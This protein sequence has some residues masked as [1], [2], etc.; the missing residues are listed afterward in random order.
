MKKF[1]RGVLIVI[2]SFVLLCIFAAFIFNNV[3][4]LI[5]V[6]M[7]LQ[8]E[9]NEDGQ[10]Y[11]VHASRT[12]PYYGNSDPYGENLIL[13]IMRATKFTLFIPKEYNGLPV[14][15]IGNMRDLNHLN[16]ILFIPDSITTITDGAF[17]YVERSNINIREKNGIYYVG[18]WAVE[19]K[20]EVNEG[21]DV[22]LYEAYLTEVSLKKGTKGIACGAFAGQTKLESITIPDSV[23]NIGDS[24]FSACS[25]LTSIHF[26]GTIEQWNAIEKS[27]N[28]N[29]ATG[30]YTVYCTDGE[31]PKE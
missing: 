23:T 25:S 24:V 26:D 30:D 3:A 17:G 9:L 12:S 20:F 16:V 5:G 21:L 19:S 1:L 31:I 18:K 13:K 8:F 7:C 28:W 10:S 2:L 4:E 11:G 14:T 6:S 27:T 22:G 29:V 15:C